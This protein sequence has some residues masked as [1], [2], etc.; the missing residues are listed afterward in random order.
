[1]HKWNSSLNQQPIP[2]TLS[3]SSESL[4][5]DPHL[6]LSNTFPQISFSINSSQDS[7]SDVHL[8]QTRTLE[9]KN[10]LKQK[11]SE[12]KRSSQRLLYSFK[13]E[14]PTSSQS[15]VLKSNSTNIQKNFELPINKIETRIND[16]NFIVSEI[17][18]LQVKIRETQIKAEDEISEL[19][20]FSEKYEELKN[21]LD[22]TC[23]M[24]N[25]DESSFACRTGNCGCCVI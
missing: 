4:S 10:Y 14:I 12:L 3:L 23:E 22:Q 6:I 15:I 17:S 21:K 7:S 2:V 13:S 9:I 11:I 16:L 1:M 20:K 24:I 19:L 25:E 5:S 8:I 18:G